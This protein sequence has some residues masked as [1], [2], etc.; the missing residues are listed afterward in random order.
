MFTI[1]AFAI[2]LDEKGQVLL[3]HRRDADMWN[4]PGGG[5]N[6]GETPWEAVIREV[7][8]ETGLF[9]K[10]LRLTGIYSKKY[11][12][13]L[14]FNFLCQIIG[15]DLTP[16]D[17]ADQH[18]YFALNEIPLNTIPKQVERINDALENHSFVVLKNQEKEAQVVT[19]FFGQQQPTPDTEGPDDDEQPTPAPDPDRPR[20]PAG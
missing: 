2:I 16:T 15:G 6:S 14:V 8:E 9:V 12:D 13:D 20:P 4:L 5:L 19:T 10:T 7:L 3:S 18:C 17:E 11:S 1:G